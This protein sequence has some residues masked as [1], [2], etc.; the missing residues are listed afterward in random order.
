MI[1]KIAKKIKE[2]VK[3]V[4]R[5]IKKNRFNKKRIKQEILTN[6]KFI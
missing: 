2:S 5:D 6:D 4:K 1:K 3:K